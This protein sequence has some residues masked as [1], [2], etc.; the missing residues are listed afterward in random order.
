M[1]KTDK[2]SVKSDDTDK[3]TCKVKTFPFYIYLILGNEFC[4]RYSYYGMR[5]V[6]IIYLTSFIGYDDNTATIIYH[7]FSVIVYLSPLVGAALADGYFGKYRVIL[8]LSLFYWVGE[9]LHTVSALPQFSAPNA[10][11]R[12]TN[13]ILNIASLLIMAFGA[14]GIKPNVSSFGGDQFL[15]V[16]EIFR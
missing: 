7:S 4:E 11:F 10:E 13:A 9:A 2:D 6:L 8:W 15:A 5:T 16:L 1:D 12:K 14:G 3:E